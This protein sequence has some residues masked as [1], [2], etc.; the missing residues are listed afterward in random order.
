MSNLEIKCHRLY[1]LC[2]Q[3]SRRYPAGVAFYNEANGDYRLSIDTFCENKVVYLKP[4]SMTEELVNFRVE[5]AIRK[6]DGIG[7]HHRAEIGVGHANAE[8]GFPIYMDIG[9]FDRT[10]VL[11]ASA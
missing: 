6:K 2:N 11:E 10:L 8:D 5:S 1:W 4:V 9:P 7:V 3:T